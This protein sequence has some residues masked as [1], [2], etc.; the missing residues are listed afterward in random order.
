MKS[1]RRSGWRPRW[2]L[3][4]VVMVMAPL[5]SGVAMAPDAP[6]L[7][8]RA[9]ASSSFELP[10]IH[11]N[12]SKAARGDV[13][14]NSRY[15]A[16]SAFCVDGRWSGHEEMQIVDLV[17]GRVVRRAPALNP[18]DREVRFLDDRSI[19]WLTNSFD[20]VAGVSYTTVHRAY[21]DGR[22]RSLAIPN[23]I[24]AGS[25][26]F[27]VLPD[28]RMLAIGGGGAWAGSSMQSGIAKNGALGLVTYDDETIAVDRVLARSDLPWAAG[29]QP[30]FV[31][32]I[33]WIDRD[34]LILMT[35]G[36]R[37]IAPGGAVSNAF[38]LGVVDTWTGA[39]APE[40][41]GSAGDVHVWSEPDVRTGL[42]AYMPGG[43]PFEAG[44]FK[45]QALDL[46]VRRLSDLEIVGGV[47]DGGLTG[48]AL[49]LDGRLLFTVDANHLDVY[50]TTAQDVFP[51]PDG[52]SVLVTGEHRGVVLR[53]SP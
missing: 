27:S 41:T 9:K 21:I 4:L 28:R 15:F 49:S 18:V 10:C 32:R 46:I 20:E 50:S 8:E 48:Y 23:M 39:M 33:A 43:A 35:Q 7:L 37:M 26:S 19:V 53:V 34:H 42:V 12:R 5:L 36:A 29:N 44:A 30:L 47:P 3:A 25:R 13:S 40:A 16:T 31:D 1:D 24:G 51:M 6:L 2:A 22:D 45:G 52:R 11:G 17:T 38:R 14:P